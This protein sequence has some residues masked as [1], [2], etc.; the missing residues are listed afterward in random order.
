MSAFSSAVLRQTS[1]SEDSWCRL[2]LQVGII[3][4]SDLSLTSGGQGTSWWRRTVRPRPGW[5]AR[6]F[7]DLPG[8]SPG[9]SLTPPPARRM[10][11]RSSSS[12]TWARRSCHAL[13]SLF[14]RT[15]LHFGQISVFDIKLV[16]I[17][18]R[19]NITDVKLFLFF[20]IKQKR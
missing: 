6:G 11:W 8:R 20:T 5:S 2:S 13:I 10:S 14:Y 17:I 15:T 19:N 3:N 12:Q 1:L 9:L 16:I 18:D 7:W 4:T